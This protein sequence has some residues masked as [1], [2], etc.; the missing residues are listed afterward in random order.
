M[1]GDKHQSDAADDSGLRYFI[2]P[3][4]NEWFDI[5]AL[6]KSHFAD[7]AYNVSVSYNLLGLTRIVIL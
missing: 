1:S 6:L 7:P 4:Q 3:L 5:F 2:S